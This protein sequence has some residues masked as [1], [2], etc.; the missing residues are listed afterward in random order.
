MRPYLPEQVPPV[1]TITSAY[2]AAHGAPVHSGDPEAI[3]ITD[4][5]HPDFGGEGE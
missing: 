2:P 1:S 3:G 5:Q 4:I